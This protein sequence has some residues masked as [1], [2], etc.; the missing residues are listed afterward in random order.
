VFPLLA[1]AAVLLVSDAP[2]HARR[3]LRVS[4]ATADGVTIAAS[5]Y[6]ASHRPA[7]A[8]VLLHMLTRTRRDWDEVAA[9]L[10]SDGFTALAIDLRGHGESSA[11]S[12]DEA[13]SA[14]AMVKDVMAA[15]SFLRGRGDVQPDRI[16]LIGA[17]LG[18]NLA[19][20]AGASNPS[21]KTIALLSPTLD[22]RGLRIEQSARKYA[23]RPMTKG[24]TAANREHVVF[25]QAGHGTTM[26]SRDGSL[27]R[28]L[29]EW[30]RRTL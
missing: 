24:N 7:P 30:C 29:V 10:A 22:Y 2:L 6:E 23:P 9:R 5:L 11:A 8:V 15:V 1:V 26:L 28:L 21:I 13:A 14:P 17:S 4:F 18:A 12:S 3:A 25:D 20:A 19:V 27:I 16:G